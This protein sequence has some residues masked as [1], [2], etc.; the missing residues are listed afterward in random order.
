[1]YWNNT[2]NQGFKEETLQPE[3]FVLAAVTVDQS[4][5]L[6]LNDNWK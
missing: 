3:N 5:H 2:Y 1:M 6:S 4:T